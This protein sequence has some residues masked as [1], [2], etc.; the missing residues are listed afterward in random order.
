MEREASGVRFDLSALSV[1]RREPAVHGPNASRKD[2][3][4]SHDRMI[5]IESR[6]LIGLTAALMA[7]FIPGLV[8]STLAEG[9]QLGTNVTIRFASV[10]QGREILTR[11]DDFI[12]ALTPLD[13]RARMQTD[14]DISE[15]DFLAFVGRSVRSWT[16]EETNRIT[17]LL[18]TLGEKLDR[19]HLPFPAVV[20]LVR[21]SG[22]EEFNNWYT[23]QNAIVFPSSDVAGRPSA[24]SNL[25]LHELFHVLSRHDPELRKA[26]YGIIGFRPINEIELPEELRQRKVTNPDGVEN[27]WRI[28]LTNQNEALHAVPILL[29]TGPSFNP[30]ERGASPYNYFRLLVVKPD[31]TNC[32]AQRVAGRPRLLRPAETTGWFEQIGRNTGYTIHP[33]EI[34]ADNFIRLI[35]G[36]TSLPS[37]Q[38]IAAV[39]NAFRQPASKK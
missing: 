27:G 14:Q 28:G 12:A 21:T 23:R 8:F 20:L 35:N 31:G 34:L 25:L 7:L 10:E 15:K 4:T 13:R 5:L 6:S 19:W 3:A 30:N 39:A 32:M 29:A 9:I 22:E 26:C 1:R 11:R 38:I 17:S 37:P 18:Q 33:D 36:D 2:E 16:P 24:L